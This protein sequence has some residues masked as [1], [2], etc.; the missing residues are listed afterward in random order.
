VSGRELIAAG[1]GSDIDLALRIGVSGV[2]PALVD[3]VLRT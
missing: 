3:G 1:D 2:V